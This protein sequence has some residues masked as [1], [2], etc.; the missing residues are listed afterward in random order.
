MNLNSG[1]INIEVQY[2]F[3]N[4]KKVQA[5]IQHLKSKLKNFRFDEDFFKFS[6][7]RVT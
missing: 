4:F 5:T 7:E 2:L 1:R 3:E 6:D